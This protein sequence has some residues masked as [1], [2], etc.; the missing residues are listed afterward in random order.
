LCTNCTGFYYTPESTPEEPGSLE[1]FIALG[2]IDLLKGVV[3]MVMVGGS[4]RWQCGPLLEDFGHVG[5]PDSKTSA[6]PSR[7]VIQIGR[8]G[9]S[10]VD[11]IGDDNSVRSIKKVNL[12]CLKIV[13]STCYLSYY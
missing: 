11:G 3:A 10:R 13:T 8:D 5:V 12:L 6:Y 9:N 7:G 4:A 1:F 2:V